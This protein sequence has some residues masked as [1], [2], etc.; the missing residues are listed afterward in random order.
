MSATASICSL[1]RLR[2]STFTYDTGPV[3][4]EPAKL[5]MSGSHTVEQHNVPLAAADIDQVMSLIDDAALAD[6]LRPLSEHATL[7][8][9]HGGDEHITHYIVR[10]NGAIVGYLHLDLTD[11]VAGPSAEVVV[12]PTA[13]NRGIGSALLTASLRN[14][15]D[16]KFRLWAHGDGPSAQHLASRMG[17]H[18]ERVLWQMRRSLYAPLPDASLPQGVSLSQFDPQRDEGDWVE[19]NRRAFADLPDQGRWTLHDLRIRTAEPWFD[20]AGL[21]I[22]RD[23]QGT[24]VGSHWTKVHGAHSHGEHVHDAIGEVYVLGVDPQM[25]GTGL[26]RALT[27]AGLQHLRAQGL[28]SVMLYVD[29][30]NMAAVQLYSSLG[31]SHWDTDVMYRR[32]EDK[33]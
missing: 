2:L 12:A 21:L 31:F 11:L 19:L 13:R 25:R 17:F 23:V 5:T 4:C 29:A 3:N 1:R 7:H 33:G 8:L 10:D 15:S 28:G 14:T 22:A 20:P 9:R 26:G 32:G 6:G 24:L 30:G 18:R 16:G 27:V